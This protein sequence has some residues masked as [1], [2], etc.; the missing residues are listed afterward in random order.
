M[1]GRVELDAGL[2]RAARVAVFAS[3]FRKRGGAMP[4]LFLLIG[5]LVAAIACGSSPTTPSRTANTFHAEVTDAAS[6]AVVSAAL[7]TPPDLIRG[8]L[9]VGGAI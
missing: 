6:D 1:C 8:T 9:D 7:P 4:R 5:V 3:D 2:V